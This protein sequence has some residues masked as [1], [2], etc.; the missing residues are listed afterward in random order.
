MTESTDFT[1]NY[2]VRHTEDGSW[3]EEPEYFAN[4]VDALERY[5]YLRTHL[6]GLVELKACRWETVVV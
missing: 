2:R 4:K 1:P 3:K 6:V 5:V